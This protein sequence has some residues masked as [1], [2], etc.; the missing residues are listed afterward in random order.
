MSRNPTMASPETRRVPKPRISSSRRRGLRFRAIASAAL[1]MVGSAV[2]G[3]C[4]RKATPYQ[5]VQAPPEDPDLVAVEA[6]IYWGSIG[7]GSPARAGTVLPHGRAQTTRAAFD[8]NS[9]VVVGTGVLPAFRMRSQ[10]I[11]A[12]Y[13]VHFYVDDTLWWDVGARERPLP[14]GWSDLFGK[15]WWPADTGVHVIRMVLDPTHRV[16]EIDESNNEL[17]FEVHVIPGDLVAGVIRFI[18]WTNGY[19]DEVSEVKVGTP[20]MVVAESFAHG[21][22]PDHRAVLSACGTEL[23]DHRVSLYGGTL[24]PDIRDDTLSFT[25]TTPGS[26]EIRFAVDPDGEFPFDSNRGDNTSVRTITVRP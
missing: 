14:S 1:L 24:W 3:G 9:T 20:V 17:R 2:L 16:A 11:T 10:G 25:P 7:I 4:G 26:C 13:R 6:F 15:M 8:E 23:F 19:P 22:Y 21:V 12:D 5:P 18:Q